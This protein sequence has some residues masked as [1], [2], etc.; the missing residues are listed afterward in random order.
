MSI[1]HMFSFVYGCIISRLIFLTVHFSSSSVT[2][3]IFVSP[4]TTFMNLLPF[5]LISSCLAALFSA[6]FVEYIHYSY[7]HMFQP[8]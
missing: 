1:T 8:S 3:T 4:F 7:L 2:L 6:I 5:F